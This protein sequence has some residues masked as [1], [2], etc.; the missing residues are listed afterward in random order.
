MT[1]FKKRK[2]R[3]HKLRLPNLTIQNKQIFNEKPAHSS[4]R[5]FIFVNS[6]NLCNVLVR[7]TVQILPFL[8][9]RLK[10]K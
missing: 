4:L 2:P 3:K 7:E 5:P 1:F 9:Y 6:F 8:V 10:K